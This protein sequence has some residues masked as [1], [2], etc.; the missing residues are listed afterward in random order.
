MNEVSQV[1]DYPH[2]SSLKSEISST[3]A[4]R[5]HNLSMTLN[6]IRDRGSIT[7]AELIHLTKLSAPTISSLVNI[8]I[9]SDFVREGGI[10]L[11]SGGRK[12]VVLEFNYEARKIMGIDMG[13]THITI[14]IMN[15]KERSSNASLPHRRNFKTGGIPA[16][17]SRR[18]REHS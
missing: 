4:M 14:I 7:R 5:A 15:L 18:D 17:H 12:P 9:G 6:L 2:I 11:S 10:G 16:N 1:F 3:A 13:A 8:L